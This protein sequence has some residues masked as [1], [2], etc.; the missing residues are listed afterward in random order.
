MAALRL[1]V[2]RRDKG[3][4]T[5]ERR[6]KAS[7]SARPSGLK[8][9]VVSQGGFSFGTYCSRKGGKTA[10]RQYERGIGR[11]SVKTDFHMKAP[12]KGKGQA[13]CGRSEYAVA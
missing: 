3:S 8:N 9:H 4:G 10:R 12:K 7:R 1:T 2:A 5:E 6:E 13:P 11:L